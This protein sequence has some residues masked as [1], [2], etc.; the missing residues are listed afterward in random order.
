MRGT[1]AGIND[2]GKAAVSRAR[3]SVW[4]LRHVNHRNL[5]TRAVASLAM[6]ADSRRCGAATTLFGQLPAV[7]LH[8]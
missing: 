8:G 5:R 4:S 3:R 6:E 1:V 7:S 2:I